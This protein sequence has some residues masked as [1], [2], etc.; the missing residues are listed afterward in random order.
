[1]NITYEQFK[2]RYA[3]DVAALQNRW[4][5]ECITFGFYADD[6]EEILSYDREYF[7]IALDGETVIGYVT[8]E[9]KT[10]NSENYMNVFLENTKF[11]HIKDLYI[12]PDYRNQNIGAELLKKVEEKANNN[13][14]KHIF[15]S[16]ATMD[17]DSVR[18]FYETNGFKIWTTTF[19]K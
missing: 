12:I 7:Y 15:L 6:E 4:S 1:M 11:L 8:G 9:I 18:R 13:A 3:K 10:N 5:D 17:A 19:F 2:N 14:V 16:S